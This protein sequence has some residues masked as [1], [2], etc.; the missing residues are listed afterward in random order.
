MLV[1]AE[2]DGCPDVRLETAGRLGVDLLGDGT[3]F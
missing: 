3:I 1:F 2:R